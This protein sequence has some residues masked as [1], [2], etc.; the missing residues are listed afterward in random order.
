MAMTLDIPTQ[1]CVRYHKHALPKLFSSCLNLKQPFDVFSSVCQT[2]VETDADTL[3]HVTTW[4]R[5]YN[6]RFVLIFYPCIRWRKC[7]VFERHLFN[8]LTDEGHVCEEFL[9]EI[10]SHI[11]TC[12]IYLS[13]SSVAIFTLTCIRSLCV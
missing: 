13:V 6:V 4:Y 7:A 12:T 2:D 10:F 9:D 3:S 11:I 8:F 5:K 1:S